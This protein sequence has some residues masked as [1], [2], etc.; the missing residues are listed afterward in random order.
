MEN[1]VR[2]SNGFSYVVLRPWCSCCREQDPGRPCAREVLWELPKAPQAARFADS[3]LA[4]GADGVLYPWSQSLFSWMITLLLHN[5]ENDR[6]WL[7]AENGIEAEPVQLV[8]S[9]PRLVVLCGAPERLASR[10]PQ[11]PAFSY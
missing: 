9:K 1:R 11:S 8:R 3:S 2:M 4:A 10:Q 7:G 6:P 5:K